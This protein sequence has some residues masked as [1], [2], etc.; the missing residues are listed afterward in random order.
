MNRV[1]VVDE[2]AEALRRSFEQVVV[3]K[4]G[5]VSRSRLDA[6]IRRNLKRPPGKRFEHH[7]PVGLSRYL[8]AATAIAEAYI[9]ERVQCYSPTQ[10]LWYLR[11][12]P[13][14]FFQGDVATTA[15]ALAAMAELLTLRSRKRT[16]VS[17]EREVSFPTG[18]EDAMVIAEFLG[19]IDYLYD[20]MV[21]SRFCA[22]GVRLEFDSTALPKSK[23]DADQRFAIETYDLRAAKRQKPFGRFGTIVTTDFDLATD[24]IGIACF[25]RS[26]E[27]EVDLPRLRIEGH[28]SRVVSATVARLYSLH[29][30]QELFRDPDL[31][32]KAVVSPEAATLFLFLRLMIPR[33]LQLR[34]GL[35]SLYRYGYFFDTENYFHSAIAGEFARAR[36][37]ILSILPDHDG[38]PETPNQLL[39]GMKRM[40]GRAIR[41]DAG[42]MCLDL[43]AA[44]ERL[45]NALEFP[46]V[47]GAHANVRATHFENQTQRVIDSSSWRPSDQV[48]QFRR[49][50]L[51]FGGKEVTDIDALGARNGTLLIISCKSEIYSAD[52][53]AG[54]YEVVRNAETRASEAI[55][56]WRSK[57]EFLSKNPVGDN[58]DFSRY[59]TIVPVVCTPHVVYVSKDVLDEFA[60]DGL[61]AACSIDELAEWIKPS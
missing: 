54:T 49:R 7:D 5:R 20:L 51:R 50:R 34:L 39:D 4:I 28:P 55:E 35:I 26:S 38:V 12:C 42:V 11:R 1:L 29:A 46:L 8:D 25:H 48:R 14:E 41:D 61:R 60:A 24:S 33:F 27:S 30:L 22:K 47:H 43:V 19:A 21:A 32:A 6:H 10:W 44:T 59:G 23:P 52:Y 40:S 37:D 16:I 3:R 18:I 13:R 36:S 17:L 45:E 31:P 57:A 58:Y 15:P 2:S 53:D 9:E 56:H